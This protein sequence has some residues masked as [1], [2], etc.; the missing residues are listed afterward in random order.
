MTSGYGTPTANY[1][2]SWV[3]KGYVNT[4]LN[5]LIINGLFVIL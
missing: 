2:H 5:L 3:V 1:L 4:K